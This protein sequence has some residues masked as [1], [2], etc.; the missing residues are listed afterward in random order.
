[1]DP[2]SI[3][4]SV[5]A[6]L[7]AGG[8]VSNGLRRLVSLKDAP[9][10]LLS[11]ESDVTTVRDA[12]LNIENLLLQ[13][14]EEMKSNLPGSLTNALNQAKGTILEVDQSVAYDLTVITGDGQQ[15]RIDKSRWLQNDQRIRTLVQKLQSDR[16]MLNGALANLTM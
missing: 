5:L 1:M 10:T 14:P 7:A 11:L 6:I 8:K 16:I 4:A 12:V 9:S 2:L 13:L 3:C 15:H